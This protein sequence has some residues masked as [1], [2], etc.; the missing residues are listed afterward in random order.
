MRI[1]FFSDAYHPRVSGQ[2][3]SIDEFSHEL[4]ERGHEVCIVCPAYP[5]ER[6]AGHEDRFRTIRV[7]SG[8]AF[9]SGEDRLALPWHSY[10]VLRQVDD[11]DPQ[12]VHIHTEFSIG[13]MGRR[14]CRSRGLP[15]LST[16]HT[17]YA[18][19]MEGYLPFLSKRV[20]LQVAR[21]WLR[22]IYSRDDLIITPSK[23]IRDEM[24][25][26]GIDREFFVI[27]TGVDDRV[28]RP[29]PEEG[30]EFRKVLA[31]ERPGF[32]GAHL[33]LY[34]GRI[35]KEKNIDLLVRALPRVFAKDPKAR[36]L[37]V[38]EG[39]YREELSQFL[40]S[41][42]LAEK[43]AWMDYQPRSRLPA[44]YSA[45][46]LFTFPSKTETQGLVTIEALL[47]G[48]PVVGVDE[49]GTGEILAGD[50]GGFLSKD[51]PEDYAEGILQLL[52]D[53]ALRREKSEQG[54]AHARLWSIP[55]LCDKIEALYHRM[56]N[57]GSDPAN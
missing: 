14:Y 18:M 51:D 13:S 27:P 55:A 42:P 24:I 21:A 56:F 49:M 16:C 30:A 20:G 15:V 40:A 2:V 28:F 17:H 31:R 11:F 52:L 7:P 26:N 10:D 12:A 43:V 39:P 53:P 29:R 41:Q 32:E 1:V 45:A 47:C 8:T 44:I 19:Y 5:Q 36:L 22:S 38:G 46:D 57:V 25:E 33:L 37:I 9:V 50:V 23:S 35:G 34:V 3:V 6:M 48:T 4:T 54:L